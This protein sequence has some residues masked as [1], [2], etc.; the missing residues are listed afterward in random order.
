MGKIRTKQN[1]RQLEAVDVWCCQCRFRGTH[2]YIGE[3]LWSTSLKWETEK[4]VGD[5]NLE[6]LGNEQTQVV[7]YGARQKTT[8]HSI[9]CPSNFSSSLPWLFLLFFLY[10]SWSHVFSSPSI[11]FSFLTFTSLFFSSLL[12]SSLL[13]PSPFFFS[14]SFCCRPLSSRLFRSLVLFFLDL[15]CH[16]ASA[17]KLFY[18]RFS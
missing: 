10:V 13:F 8:M 1:H 18:L 5:Q 4:G 11:H 14:V 2:L 17:I 16:L 7:A 9:A 12:F 15:A 3:Q 6:V